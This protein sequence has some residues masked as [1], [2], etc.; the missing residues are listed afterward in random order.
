MHQHDPDKQHW[1]ANP[2]A[3]GEKF[4]GDNR[5]VRHGAEFNGGG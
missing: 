1:Q 5:V 4:L 3:D 2:I